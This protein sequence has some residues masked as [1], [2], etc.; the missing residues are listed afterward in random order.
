VNVHLHSEYSNEN[1]Q[2]PMYISQTINDLKNKAEF[3]KLK[4]NNQV[5]LSYHD[6]IKLKY[7]EKEDMKL[8]NLSIQQGVIYLRVENNESES[9]G[10][11][12]NSDS[13]NANGNDSQTSHAS[14]DNDA[15][16][17]NNSSNS[18]NDSPKTADGS[19]RYMWLAIPVLAAVILGPDLLPKKKATRKNKS[20]RKKAKR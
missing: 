15:K 4:K 20:K 11:K 1:L 18:N 2:C 9:N 3:K 5:K 16:K 6:G 19:M 14:K 12:P 7:V 10:T 17:P 8:D 13:N